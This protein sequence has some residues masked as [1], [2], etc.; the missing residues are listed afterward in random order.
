M[1]L[2]REIGGGAFI[3]AG[4]H[5]KTLRADLID[6]VKPSWLTEEAG[7]GS[8][9]Y[10][11]LSATNPGSAVITNAGTTAAALNGPE[12]DLS[13]PWLR[14]AWFTIFN[15]KIGRASSGAHLSIDFGLRSVGAATAGARLLT[16]FPPVAWPIV[17][18]L[19]GGSALGSHELRM[20][21]G[22]RANATA[23]QAQGDSPRNLT[24]H[25]DARD[26]TVSVLMDDQV[27]YSRQRSELVLGLVR[28]RLAMARTGST[29][30]DRTL[31]V[32]GF[33]FGIETNGT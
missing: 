32:T 2:I 9:A 14:S 24:F 22:S 4:R 23:I 10:N 3:R 18:C 31:T 25:I 30:G 8:F 26:K 11:A 16:N 5:R 1:P 12:I 28:P 13:A 27:L 20:P 19:A 21:W 7:T 6:G 15:A 17:D 33:E 29:T